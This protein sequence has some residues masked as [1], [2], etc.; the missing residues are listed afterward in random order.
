M[1]QGRL[2]VRGGHCDDVYKLTPQG[3]RAL[4]DRNAQLVLISNAG[5]GDVGLAVHTDPGFLTISGPTNEMQP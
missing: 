4:R 2:E 3:V 1:S 5:Y